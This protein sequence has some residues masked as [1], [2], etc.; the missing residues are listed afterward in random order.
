M[1]CN[2]EFELWTYL[3]KNCPFWEIIKHYYCVFKSLNLNSNVPHHY[4]DFAVLNFCTSIDWERK[5]WHRRTSQFISSTSE[6]LLTVQNFYIHSDS[7][8]WANDFSC[9]IWHKIFWRL[10]TNRVICTNKVIFFSS[11][12]FTRFKNKNEK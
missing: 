2:F 7:S 9:K 3:A 6:H 5:L 1:H 4:L 11:P 10:K 8:T 12:I